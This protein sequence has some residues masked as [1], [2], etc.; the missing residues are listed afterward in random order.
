[1]IKG[2]SDPFHIDRT[3]HD[4]GILLCVRDD[5]PTKL[6]SIEPIPPNAFSLSLICVSESG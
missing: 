5:I 1:M 3:V 4:G 2:F 6:L